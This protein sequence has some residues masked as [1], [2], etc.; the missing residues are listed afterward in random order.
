MKRLPLILSS[1]AVCAGLRVAH[2]DV[3]LPPAISDH[4]VLQCDLTAPI[5]GT[6][7]PGEEVTVELAGQKKSAT[8][9]AGGKW[10]VTLDALKA[11]GP[12]TMTVKGRNAI[13]IQDV[14]VGEVW[15]GSGQ[16]NM[17]GSV[18]GFSV[19]DPVLAE[20]AKQTYPKIRFLRAGAKWAEA[21]PAANDGFS[22]ILFSFGVP[23]QRE[24]GVP[25][26]L[27]VGAVGGT[28]SGYWLTEEMFLAD[29]A[30]VAQVKQNAAL[31]QP[32][33]EEK[34]FQIALDRWKVA[35]AAAKEAG[36][37]APKPLVKPGPPGSVTGGK[38]GYLFE[39]HIRP[40]VGY[41]IRG[42]LWDQGESGTAITG[43]DQFNVMGALIRGWRK[44]W[45]RDFAFLYV[46]KPSGGGCAWDLENPVT[47]N[48]SKF[49]PLPAKLPVD[50]D[51]R[52]LHIRIQTHPNTA[53]VTSTDLGG[54]T[55]PTNKSGYGER[56]ARVALGFVYGRRVEYSGPLYASHSIEGNKI[57]IKFSH[58]GKGLAPAQ[59]E[60]LQGFEIAGAEKKFAWA[61]AVIDGD[62]V[63]VSSAE[64]PNPAAVR[65]AWSQNIPWAN[66]FNKDGLPAQAFRT[67]DWK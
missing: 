35:E 42:V 3:T 16:S 52:D 7:M 65:Y 1:L 64:I 48:A 6:A 39:A 57:R 58:V 19:T 36:K 34:K 20:A 66:L 56:A 47:R 45:G 59:S 63:L 17:A 67:D 31:Y 9:D 28:P 38:F 46:Q 53:M 55:H 11:G 61:D 33:E 29:A 37:P 4:M 49:E 44:D 62:S 5:W 24:L 54:L 41:G 43:V 32:E 14:L 26:G 13:T 25:V 27:Y 40:F 12:L 51:S 30:C 21:T 2:A 23:L 22:A 50:G 15:V 8:A 10:R 60:K 18:R